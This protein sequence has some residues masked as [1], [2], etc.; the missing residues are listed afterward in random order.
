M[1]C[2]GVEEQTCPVDCEGSYGSWSICASPSGNYP[3]FTRSRS[4]V[5]TQIPLNGSQACPE[6][7][8]EPCLPR[9][10]LLC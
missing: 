2:P 1:P 6:S 7:E 4:F 8:T 10:L 9:S 3:P 5:R